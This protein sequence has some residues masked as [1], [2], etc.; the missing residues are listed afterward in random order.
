MSGTNRGYLAVR[1][2]QS[3]DVLSG[4]ALLRDQEFGTTV[5][6][7][8]GK[9]SGSQAELRLSDFL[10]SAP[11][12]PLY[13]ELK[14]NFDKDLQ[15][16]EG[17]WQ[18]DIGTQGTCKLWPAKVARSLW[19]LRLAGSNGRIFLRRYG[20][21]VY[22]ATLFVVAVLNLVKV[23]EIS[24]PSLI[25][26]LVPVPYVFRKYLVELINAYRVRRI[27]PVELEPQNPLTEDIRRV[28]AQQVQE[29]VAFVALNGFLVLRTK[30]ILIWL[31][32]NPAVDRALFNGYAA[33]IGVPADNLDATWSAL[34]SS[35]CA[36]L[37][38]ER[39]TITDL[40]RRYVA[41]LIRQS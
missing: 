18:T 8:S 3:G 2:E 7:F 38:G 29:T 26:L 30:L 39:L 16:A 14:L 41:F 11:I 25:L 13:G 32:Q 40:G 27:G 9:L 37:T 20:A 34:I 24:Y 23:F 35:G 22:T 28:I 31:S 33:A 4:K 15:S 6:A 10:G 12:T 19:Q 36:A 17:S 5:V 21:A 1:L